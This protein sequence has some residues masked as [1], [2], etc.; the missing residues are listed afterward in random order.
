MYRIQAVAERRF[1]TLQDMND[2]IIENE[3]DIKVISVQKDDDNYIIFFGVV[4]EGE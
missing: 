4:L 1:L 2:W 3:Y